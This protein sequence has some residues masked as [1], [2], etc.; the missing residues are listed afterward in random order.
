MSSHPLVT[1]SRPPPPVDMSTIEQS[2]ENILPLASGRSARQLAT[3][4]SQS[5]SGLG[6][7]LAHEH[8]LFQAKIDAV[9]LC[10]E[11]GEWDEGRDGLSRDEVLQLAED[12]LEVHHQYAKFALEN[13][14]AGASTASKL[15]P[16]L[17]AST[18]R[19]LDYAQYRN[20][21]RYLRLWSLYA[22]NTEDPEMCYRFLFAKGIGEELAI[23]YEEYAKVLE[24]NGK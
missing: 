7:Q 20:D 4:S 22:S 23:L 15:V 3:L 11:T 16:L 24:A 19:F 8:K 14:T 6:S 10:E 12:P 17:E 1:P 5:R 13:Y 18:R 21:A 2:K 9:A